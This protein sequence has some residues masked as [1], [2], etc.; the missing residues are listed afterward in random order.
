MGQNR[1]GNYVL[2]KCSELVSSEYKEQVKRQCQYRF[3]YLYFLVV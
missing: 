3:M 1:F 2:Q